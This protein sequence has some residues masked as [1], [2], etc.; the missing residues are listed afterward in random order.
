LMITGCGGGSE[1]TT[2]AS[3]DTEW[4]DLV[5]SYPESSAFSDANRALATSLQ[6][7]Q[8][9]YLQAILLTNSYIYTDPS[10]TTYMEFEQRRQRAINAF[11]ILDDHITITLADSEAY[12]SASQYL[13]SSSEVFNTSD[14]ISPKPW[15]GK[16]PI[17]TL[18][19]KYSVSSQRAMTILIGMADE[20]TA[21]AYIKGG[22]DML[23]VQ[24]RLEQQI[25]G[26][27]IVGAAAGGIV[28][29]QAGVAVGTGGA[30]LGSTL[31]TLVLMTGQGLKLGMA[32]D[33]LMMAEKGKTAPPT[34]TVF[35]P[36]TILAEAVSVVTL[37]GIGDVVLYGTEKL[38]D[39]LKSGGKVI[40]FG[41]YEI[42]VF[43]L[44][45]A[46]LDTE[47]NIDVSK[48]PTTEPGVYLTPDGKTIVVT[49]L[50]VGYNKVIG[51]LEP[52]E[53]LITLPDIQPPLATPLDT[54][55]TDSVD[56]TLVSP[57]NLAIVYQINGG[58]LQLYTGPITLT[59]TSTIVA[60]ADRDPYDVNAE[61]SDISTFQYTKVGA[62]TGSGRWVLYDTALIDGC[63][64][65]TSDCY[66]LE[67]CTA[68][69]GSYQVAIGYSTCG[70]DTCGGDN[71][72]GTYTVPPAILTPGQTISFS[73]TSVGDG[74][75]GEDVCFYNA[76]DGVTS[77]QVIIDDGG[78]NQGI[79]PESCSDI[80]KDSSPTADWTVPDWDHHGVIKIEGGGSIGSFETSMNYYYLYKWQE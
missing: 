33:A 38:Q 53:R 5:S 55:F 9:A 72:S 78:L 43:K 15:G 37:S 26:L 34:P 74:S 71:G 73:V 11:Q 62:N 52:S 29:I 2:T 65:Y 18:M 54:E 57:D 61:Y 47:R 80:V 32:T 3:D 7:T 63:S 50:P 24:K 14:L 77:D 21:D 12:N 35:V 8:G 44:T 70:C 17:K 31:G 40:S 42:N 23:V 69:Q 19:E 68:S 58:D 48:W 16:R 25:E 30:M 39:L 20:I 27:K 64:F 60:Y 6:K 4:K 1:D 28:L 51:A 49:A 67:S 10:V 59:E 79:T 41:P 75:T 36:F 13:A 76:S 66:P 56:V 22:N 45:Q 46:A